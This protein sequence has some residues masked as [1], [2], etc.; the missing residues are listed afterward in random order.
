MNVKCHELDKKKNGCV[1]VTLTETWWTPLI[2]KVWWTFMPSYFKVLQSL[3]TRQEKSAL[4]YHNFHHR[5][6]R[7]DHD[8]PKPMVNTWSNIKVLTCISMLKSRDKTSNRQKKGP[9][10]AHISNC[11]WHCS[12]CKQ[13]NNWLKT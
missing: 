4:L 1:S 13:F 6:Q 9:L 11:C 2:L 10:H 8:T 5:I 12:F 7:H 3:L